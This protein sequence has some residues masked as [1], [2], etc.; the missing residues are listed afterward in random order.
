MGELSMSE[1]TDLLLAGDTHGNTSHVRYL[2]DVAHRHGIDRI[3]QVGDF[4]AWEHVPDGRA[5]FDNV[6]KYARRRGVTVYWLDGNHDKT[7]LIL[8]RYGNELD[9]EGFLRCR[10]NVRYAPRGHRWTWGGVRFIALGGA[11]SVDKPWRVKEERAKAHALAEKA[12]R[13]GS[14]KSTDTTGTLWFPEEELTD[15]ELAAALADPTPVDVMLTHDKPRAADPQWNRKDLAECWPNQDRIQAA[16]RALRPRLLVHGH[17]HYPYRD[18]IRSSGDAWTT[19]IGLDA[20]PAAADH[21][22]YDKADSWMVLDLAEV[23]Q[24]AESAKRR[25]EARVKKARNEAGDDQ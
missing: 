8:E 11:Y 4:G 24:G 20:D 23:A 25:A 1:P 19:V 16:V 17:L 12:A 15:A 9:D 18:Q 10:E 21:A 6:D 5:F 3:F 7:S 13:Y 2:I 14:G 22:G